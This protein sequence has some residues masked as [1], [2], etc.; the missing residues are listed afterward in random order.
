L[1]TDVFEGMEK[2]ND[3][4]APSTDD[5]FDDDLDIDDFM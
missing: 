5:D 4:P 1:E 3:S 2:G